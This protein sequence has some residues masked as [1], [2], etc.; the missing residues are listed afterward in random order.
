M[1]HPIPRPTARRL[2]ALLTAAGLVAGLLGAVLYT[3][4]PDRYRA[5]AVLAML[6]GPAVAPADL[7]EAWRVLTAE[8]QATRTAAIVLSQSTP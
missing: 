6:P 2:V 1:S 4:R 3:G 8:G 5:H 7:P